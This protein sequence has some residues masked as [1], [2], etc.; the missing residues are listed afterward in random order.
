[1]KNFRLYILRS[2]IRGFGS[3]M[4]A[5]SIIALGIFVYVAMS[6]ILE[7]LTLQIERYYQINQIADVFVTLDGISSKNIEQLKSISGIADVSGKMA[8]NARLL[9]DGEDKF[10]T[11]HLM[12]YEDSDSLNKIHNSTIIKYENG[13]FLGKKMVE[14]N[15]YKDGTEFTLLINGKPKKSILAGI[16][17]APNYVYA[18]PSSGSIFPD[19]EIYDIG[20]VDIKTMEE[21]TGKKDFYQELGIR[22]KPGYTYEDVRNQL[23]D[24]L[25]QYGISDIREKENQGSYAMVNKQV[26]QLKSIG[27]ILPIMFLSVSIFM[28][29]VL[30][31]KMVEKDQSVIGTMK[32]LG[33]TDRE[34][35]AS[36][37]VQGIFVGVIGAIIGGLL[38]IPVGKNMFTLYINL[39][40][41]P[42]SSYHN[43]INSRVRGLLFAIITSILAVYLGVREILKITPAQAMRAKAPETVFNLKLPLNI[44]NKVGAMERIGIRSIARNPFRGCLII[45]AIGF[46]FSMTSILFSFN[47]VTEQMYFQQFDMI[48]TYDEQITLLSANSS[49]K[50]ANS[51]M[52]LNGVKKSEGIFQFTVQLQNQNKTEFAKLYGLNK[53]SDMWRIMDIYG[54]YYQPPDDG[55]II[56]SHTAKKLN[57]KKGDILEVT[58]AGLSSEKIKIPVTE[59]IVE[60]FGSSCYMSGEGI[61]RFWHSKPMVNTIII[62]AKSGYLETLQKQILNAKQVTWLVDTNRILKS[63]KEQMKSTVLMVNMFALISVAAGGV[64]IYNISM[65]NIRERIMEF[66]TLKLMGGKDYEIGRILLF[67]Q[68]LYFILGFLAGI[69][70]SLGVRCLLEKILSTDA[71][72]I[73]LFTQIGAY[74]KALVICI[75]ITALSYS[76]QVRVVKKIQITE[77]LKERE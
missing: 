41:L 49:I 22:L 44:E 35:I 24:R 1:M 6:D 39:F 32:A 13:I 33:M 21:W 60:N 61:Q 5:A 54:S 57:I 76:A 45:L 3:L 16:C 74:F 63:Y 23:I 14:A 38:A 64:L 29:Y 9:L 43:F 2:S 52:N 37:M 53:N 10:I 71:F 69:P 77:V 18:I 19:G 70:G 55:I 26:R 7:N 58:Y 62:D 68:C 50:T 31:K 27:T 72:T 73:V 17:F 40:S 30:L 25:S 4:G 28:L 11:V 34:L 15:H 12:S 67:E 47:Q 56:D 51:S 42:D 66:G 36:Y 20:S 59:V 65:I 75:I 48:Q 8:V 46:P